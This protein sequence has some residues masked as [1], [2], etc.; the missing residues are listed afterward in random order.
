MAKNQYHFCATCKH[1]KVLKT[2]GKTNYFC[3]RLGF[4]TKSNYQF[5]CWDPKDNVVKLM[6][7]R[8]VET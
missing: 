1:F 3:S 7:Q 8:R 6:Q 4:E 5:D 2:N